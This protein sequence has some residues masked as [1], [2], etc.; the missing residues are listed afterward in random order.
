MKRPPSCACGCKCNA[1]WT[2]GDNIRRSQL[3][4]NAQLKISSNPMMDLLEKPLAIPLDGMPGDPITL[5]GGPLYFGY[6]PVP[7]AGGGLGVFNI[8]SNAV[9]LHG[10][11]EY[12]DAALDQ[13]SPFDNAFRAPISYPATDPVPLKAFELPLAAPCYWHEEL[14]FELKTE[15]KEIGTLAESQDITTTYDQ[16]LF[17]P[18][19]FVLNKSKLY[20]YLIP[21]LDSYVDGVPTRGGWLYVRV[22][23]NDQIGDTITPILGVPRA[24]VRFHDL[25]NLGTASSLHPSS[26]RISYSDAIDAVAQTVTDNMSVGIR[27]DDLYTRPNI[28]PGQVEVPLYTYQEIQ[29]GRKVT[30]RLVVSS[31]ATFTDGIW[32]V[33]PFVYSA[34]DLTYTHYVT[35]I[36][37]QYRA[38]GGTTQEPFTNLAYTRGSTPCYPI[39]N[40][41]RVG[42]PYGFQSRYLGVP[43]GTEAHF[44]MDLIALFE[45]W[46]VTDP[47]TGLFAIMG[48]YEPI[49]GGYGL[50]DV[51]WP[52]GFVIGYLPELILPVDASHP[53]GF[54]EDLDP[55]FMDIIGYAMKGKYYL[56]SFIGTADATMLYTEHNDKKKPYNPYRNI[57]TLQARTRDSHGIAI[58]LAG[59][60]GVVDSS[61]YRDPDDPV[62]VTLTPE[63]YVSGDDT[64]LDLPRSVF[65]EYSVFSLL[66]YPART[67]IYSGHVYYIGPVNVDCY[68]I[69]GATMVRDVI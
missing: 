17:N 20:K 14:G 29:Q 68:A 15:I 45:S 61:D 59:Y 51:T 33:Q 36:W 23:Y 24:A 50:G 39:V 52:D 18:L 54:V 34:V 43:P 9:R 66:I 60:T 47:T 25:N 37:P 40:E 13:V 8:N 28:M 63:D 65:G 55:P 16:L 62:V 46:E 21:A 44:P 27:F 2:P 19:G 26:K 12:P 10:F 64:W 53:Q 49:G 6:T 58:S 69:P 5:T 57:G 3:P 38:F 41:P 48:V 56:P 1:I 11:V 67:P 30:E 35:V 22:Y 42:F 32:F 31:S 7:G 4:E